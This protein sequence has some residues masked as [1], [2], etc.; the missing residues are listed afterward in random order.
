MK[1]PKTTGIC[2]ALLALFVLADSAGAQ[3][4]VQRRLH[5]GTYHQRFMQVIQPRTYYYSTPQ[6]APV[7]QQESGETY[8]SF[9]FEPGTAADEPAVQTTELPVFQQPAV[10]RRSAPNHV[11]VIAHRRQHPGGK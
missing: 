9:S 3:S 8:R 10:S 1:V 11:G 6:V 4:T 7:I 5:P 2:A